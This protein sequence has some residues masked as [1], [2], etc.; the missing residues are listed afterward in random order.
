MSD[1]TSSFSSLEEEEAIS[2]FDSIDIPVESETITA[3]EAPEPP[4][5]SFATNDA[6]DAESLSSIAEVSAMIHPADI[7][8]SL[9][10]S[11][12][13]RMFPESNEFKPKKE[14]L[15]IHSLI[16]LFELLPAWREDEGHFVLDGEITDNDVMRVEEYAESV[17]EFIFPSTET[18]DGSN[19]YIYPSVYIRF[20]QHI[21][22]PLFPLLHSVQL[23]SVSPVLQYLPLLVSC[24]LTRLE[25]G[26]ISLPAI[27]L[28]KSFLATLPYEAPYIK[29]LQ[30]HGPLQL[31]EASLYPI[32]KLKQLV[33]LELD[34]IVT[35]KGTTLLEH[36]ST[37]S[38]LKD[39][40]LVMRRPSPTLSPPSDS[41]VGSAGFPK[42]QHL[43]IAGSLDL[44]LQLVHLVSSQDLHT[45]QLD[46][47]LEEHSEQVEQLA[48]IRKMR[49]D[50]ARLAKEEIERARG[51]EIRTSQ[52]EI[53]NMKLK[54]T[55]SESILNATEHAFQQ[56]W[57]EKR[58]KSIK[59]TLEQM[60]ASG[61]SSATIEET[62]KRLQVGQPWPKVGTDEELRAANSNVEKLKKDVSALQAKL[63][64]L[65]LSHKSLL[66]S[67]IPVHKPVLVPKLPPPPSPA[68]IAERQQPVDQVVDIVVSHWRECLK[69]FT[70]TLSTDGT[71][72]SSVIPAIKLSPVLDSITDGWPDIQTLHLPLECASGMTFDDLYSIAQCCPKLQS[73]RTK[74]DISALPQLPDDC[75]AEFALLHN[76]NTLI[77][78][79]DTS[80]DIRHGR[81]IIARYLN[82]LFPNLKTIASLA[83]GSVG[84]MW[85]EVH[86]Q[87][88]L[89]QLIR[90]DDT[91]R[92]RKIDS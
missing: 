73:L 21:P 31:P 22:T 47:L 76:L 87:V 51:S 85:T 29:H 7:S 41:A 9:T 84:E 63:S 8:T 67:A 19:I 69:D 88:K 45:L 64:S 14:S 35:L 2:D 12:E 34:D 13:D 91:C 37:L 66:S 25:I 24:R 6:S 58:K 57:K 65:E 23:L 1:S 71:F 61:S 78:D 5:A 80:V 68:R 72:C 56:L 77:V 79:G 36:L 70:M 16:P 81:T 20:L 32:A 17:T 53:D 30:L 52:S 28:V 4:K 83:S 10:L 90:R 50:E 44:T 40:K 74:I 60:R 38:F 27:H 62:R 55:R 18:S 48:Q 59:K 33:S 92:T 75:G 49:E 54:L 42:L 26:S 89:F 39:I 46:V 82:V 86:E 15:Q 43:R 11:P 3:Q